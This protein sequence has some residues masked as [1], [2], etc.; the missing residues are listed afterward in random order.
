MLCQN[1][2]AIPKSSSH[3][4]PHYCNKG[5]DHKDLIHSFFKMTT[6]NV[7][8]FLAFLPIA[9]VLLLSLYSGNNCFSGMPLWS[10]EVDYWR[11]V[12]SF[13]SLRSSGYYGFLGHTPLLGTLGC[14]GWTPILVYG[15]PALLFGWNVFS[16]VAWNIFLCSIA[17]L[18]LAV[19]VRPNARTCFYISIIWLLFPCILFYIPTSMM[20]MPHYALLIVFEALFVH[21]IR[22]KD[23][24]TRALI[25]M[26]IIVLFMMSLRINEIVF[27]LQILVLIA[28]YKNRK[29]LFISIAIFA[30]LAIAD[31][32]IQG[33][34]SSAYPFG[35]LYEISIQESFNAKLH[36]IYANVHDNMLRFFSSDDTFAQIIQRICT[37]IFLGV[38]CACFIQ[39]AFTKKDTALPPNKE[40]VDSL[41]II[42]PIWILGCSILVISLSLVLVILFYDVMIWRDYRTLAPILWS[43]FL[44][45]ALYPNRMKFKSFTLLRTVLLIL[46]ILLFLCSFPEMKNGAA[47]EAERYDIASITTDI[48][49]KRDEIANA[50]EV[51]EINIKSKTAVNLANAMPYEFWFTLPPEIGIVVT[52]SEVEALDSNMRYIFSSHPLEEQIKYDLILTHQGCYIYRLNEL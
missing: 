31:Y 19:L 46:T 15:V 35:V 50:L 28:F 16:I 14:H 52:T 2:T 18:V 11:E 47:F 42:P 40:D 6:M 5:V 9:T 17:F 43:Q 22:N 44:L 38:L 4:K 39:Q 34:F 7:G 41:D 30:C 26:T 45:F 48:D 29:T 51:S 20:E 1:V 21:S 36:L 49:Q 8:I 33:L 25:A 32:K 3:K 13:S 37:I 12:Y 27:F 24:N 10:D 23:L